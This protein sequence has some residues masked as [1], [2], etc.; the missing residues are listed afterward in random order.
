MFATAGLNSPL[1]STP[2]PINTALLLPQLATMCEMI[3]DDGDEVMPSAAL[4]SL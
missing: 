2:K 3:L 4:T 1:Q